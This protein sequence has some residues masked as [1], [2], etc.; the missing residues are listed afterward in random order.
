MGAL[1]QSCAYLLCLNAS[2]LSA[3]LPHKL[4]DPG[5]QA[6]ACCAFEGLLDIRQ[7]R[8]PCQV[9]QIMGQAIAPNFWRC[10]TLG[11]SCWELCHSILLLA[12][13]C[14]SVTWPPARLLLLS[15]RSTCNVTD[16]PLTQRSAAWPPHLACSCG[17][18]SRRRYKSAAAHACSL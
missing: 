12:A 17:Y 10:G 15:W 4:Q 11:P 9:Q 1:Q 6:R 13:R 16:P 18:C 3:R 7:H 14:G 8:W 5:H 2:A